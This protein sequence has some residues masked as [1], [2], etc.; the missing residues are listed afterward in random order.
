M[1]NVHAPTWLLRMCMKNVQRIPMSFE[2]T[3][4]A[5]GVGTPLKA[6]LEVLV[7]QESGF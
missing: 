7:P 6:V 1:G 3:R 5:K 4:V 2:R